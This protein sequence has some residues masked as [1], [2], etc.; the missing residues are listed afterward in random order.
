VILFFVGFIPIQNY[1]E[2]IL[3]PRDDIRTY[4]HNDIEEGIGFSL[5]VRQD[6]VILTSFTEKEDTGVNC[7]KPS[8]IQKK[9]TR[10][11]G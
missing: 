5:M 1:I 2:E 9:Q 6:G 7:M 3:Y 11:S 8:T 4:L 10:P